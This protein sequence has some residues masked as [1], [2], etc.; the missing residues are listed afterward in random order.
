MIDRI[1]NT[2]DIDSPTSLRIH[3]G[4]IEINMADKKEL[5]TFIKNNI[6]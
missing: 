5:N 6:L 2:E 3:K 1:K 4:N